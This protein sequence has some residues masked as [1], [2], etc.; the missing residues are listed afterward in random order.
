MCGTVLRGRGLQVIVESAVADTGAE[1]GLQLLRG[2]VAGHHDVVVE[3]D[4][5]GGQGAGSQVM[6]HSAGA[7]ELG[8]SSKNHK[9]GKLYTDVCRQKVVSIS[10]DRTIFTSKMQ[11]IKEHK[12]TAM[13]S[14]TSSLPLA[15]LINLADMFTTLPI[16]AYSMRL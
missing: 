8:R 1:L 13:Y 10:V 16:A 7:S 3:D 6:S 9:Y 5:A 14:P 4:G 2:R 15:L 12:S 11:Q